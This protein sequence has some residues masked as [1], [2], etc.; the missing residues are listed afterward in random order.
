MVE[1]RGCLTPEEADSFVAVAE[2]VGFKHS[3]SRGPAYGEVR[4]AA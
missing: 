3:T 1:V 4:G 2:S